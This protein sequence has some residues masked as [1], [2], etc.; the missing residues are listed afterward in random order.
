MEIRPVEHDDVAAIC[1][2]Y[3]HYINHTTITFEEVPLGVAEMQVRIEA[4]RKAFPWLVCEAGGEVVGYA[5]ASKWKERAAYRHT[6]EATVYVRDGLSRRGYGQ[7]LYGALLPRLFQLGCHAVAGCI[8]LPNEPSVNL[9]ERIGFRK[10]AH[11]P[12]V[13]RKFGSWIDIGYWQLAPAGAQA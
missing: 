9:H 6:A 8:A 12:E 10:V 11:F 4:Y 3:N 5:Y 7:A 13:G 1:D 2:I